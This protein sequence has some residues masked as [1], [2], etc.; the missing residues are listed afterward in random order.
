MTKSAMQ[1]GILSV[2]VFLLALFGSN[3]FVRAAVSYPVIITD[4]KV[5][6]AT[7]ITIAGYGKQ[8]NDDSVQHSKNKCYN[9]PGLYDISVSDAFLASYV[10]RGFTLNSLCLG[11]NSGIR[12][13]PETGRHLRTFVVLDTDSLQPDHDISSNDLTNEIPVDV[14]GCFRNG[15]PYADCKMA[16]DPMTGARL[17]SRRSQDYRKLGQLIDADLTRKVQ[18]GGYAK[19]CDENHPTDTCNRDSRGDGWLMFEDDLSTYLEGDHG[20]RQWEQQQAFDISPS[21]PKGFGYSLYAHRGGGKPDP[22]AETKKKVQN[23]SHFGSLQ[24][25]RAA[26][27]FAN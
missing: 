19:P 2:A 9:E 21:F 25:V 8:Y 4:Q 15:T 23:A 1:R 12:F 14:P 13:D 6:Q 22:T 11:L 18:S 26:L 10:R 24:E 16:F 3:G 27:A 7:G 5:L 20:R 17:D